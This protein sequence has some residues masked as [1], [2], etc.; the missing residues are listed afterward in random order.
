MS[1][2]IHTPLIE[3]RPLSLAA[4]RS[5]WLKL[6][7]LQP[8]GSFKLRGV[9]HACEVHHARGARHFVSS[10]GGN[11]G[12]AVAYAGRKL[13]VPVTVVVPETT[14]ERA[15]ELLRQEDAKVVV[16]GSSW[17]EA[18]ALALTLV[19][20]NDAFIHPFDDQLLW[21]GHASLVDEL[22]AAGFKPDAV[23]LS[24]GGGGLLSGVVEGLERNGWSDVPVLAVETEGAASLH[25]AMQA[26][27]TVE[28]ERIASLATSLGA[29]RV[30]EQ[31]LACTRKHPVHSHLVSDRA[32]LEACQRFLR[33]HR[34]LVEPACGAALALVQEPGAL[35]GFDKVLVVVCG[36]ATAT[37]EQI[38]AW[39]EQAS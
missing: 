35:A 28:L 10:S 7:A 36:G 11:A 9:G 24:V 14:T 27:H 26:G 13:G 19:G 16:H 17:Q 23:V 18:N 2:H 1:L 4:G 39:L 31:A 12:L 30:A 33:D 38:Q 6:D 3:S 8:C 29:K 20:A 22:A 37:L 32:A 5:V 25:A 21:T 15:K 34:V